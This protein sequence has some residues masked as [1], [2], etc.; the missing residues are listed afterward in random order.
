MSQP[1]T[2]AITA[3]TTYANG[4]TGASD[5]T[6]SDAVSTLADGYGG[7][8]GGTG[9]RTYIIKDGKMQTGYSFS[10]IQGTVTE[11]TDGTTAYIKCEATAANSYFAVYTPLINVPSGAKAVV[12]ELAKIGGSYGRGWISSRTY[13]NL[14]LCYDLNPNIETNLN[15]ATAVAPLVRATGEI[16]NSTFVVGGF[17]AANQICVHINP[18]G[19]SSCKGLVNIKNLYFTDAL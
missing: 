14:S 13:S 17:L 5:T 4:V 1:L 15:K 2:D 18:S 8:G 19:W 10:A 11:E 9:N 3:L 6:L 16:P 7:G 12:M